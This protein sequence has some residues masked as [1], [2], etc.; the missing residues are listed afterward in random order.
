MLS[1][2]STSLHHFPFCG[3]P[4]PIYIYRHLSLSTS[5]K[6]IAS[7]CNPRGLN[8]RCT[9]MANKFID[10]C[11]HTVLADRIM[12]FPVMAMKT[13]LQSKK[14]IQNTELS[15]HYYLPKFCA[16][17]SLNS[18]F[19]SSQVPFVPVTF[20]YTSTE[21]VSS[22]HNIDKFFLIDLSVTV[23]VSFLNH[24]L[25]LSLIQLYTRHPRHLLQ[26]I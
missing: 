14:K 13:N 11:I 18:F 20:S 19:S 3:Y 10:W 7:V 23:L 26:V 22:L 12:N 25:Q 5:H 24:F 4:F 15:Y 8:G 6:F 1:I 17:P 2:N 16:A 9:E 21:Q